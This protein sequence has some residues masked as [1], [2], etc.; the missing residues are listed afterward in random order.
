MMGLPDGWKSVKIGLAVLIQYQHV[1]DRQPPS[2]VAEYALC[3]SASRSKNVINWAI[4]Q[5]S[6]VLCSNICQNSNRKVTSTR[7]PGYPFQ[8]ASDTRFYPRSWRTL[9]PVFKSR[10]FWSRISQKRCVFGTKLLKNT[11]RKPY[12]VYRMKPLSM[13]FSGLWPGFQG[14][15][16]FEVECLK[17]KVTIL[18]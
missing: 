10:H 13:T 9:K 8:Y 15:D 18:H 5:H 1:T 2:H 16:I 4:Q 7:V 3:I 17:D 14:H 6:V 12:K 11:N